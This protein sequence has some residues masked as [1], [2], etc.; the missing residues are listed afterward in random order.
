MSFEEQQFQQSLT[1]KTWSVTVDKR[2]LKL[3]G[4]YV[5]IFLLPLQQLGCYQ[6]PVSFGLSSLLQSEEYTLRQTFFILSVN[7][8][9]LVQHCC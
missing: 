9:S 8:F 2:L 5:N 7:D 3:P 1:E 4:S 6:E